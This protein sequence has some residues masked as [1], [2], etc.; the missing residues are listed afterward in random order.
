M[1]GRRE[2]GGSPDILYLVFYVERGR[3]YNGREVLNSCLTRG[4]EVPVGGNSGKWR[5]A[6][7]K[8]PST[9]ERGHAFISAGTGSIHICAPPQHLTHYLQVTICTCPHKG[10]HAI[11]RSEQHSHLHPAPAAR[12]LPPSTPYGNAHVPSLVHAA[13]THP[14]THAHT[15]DDK[16]LITQHSHWR[17]CP[18]TSAHAQDRHF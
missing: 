17:P 16:A 12:A 5:R 9:Q 13:F 4:L 6:I 1:I 3:G 7:T 2:E 15:R 14:L 8:Y 11:A 18:A 10:S